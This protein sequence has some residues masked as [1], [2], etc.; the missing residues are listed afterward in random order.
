M[1]A[2]LL[3]SPD[4]PA[5]Q[6]MPATMHPV[7]PGALGS[8]HTPTD[9][10]DFFVQMPAQQ[11]VSF[12]QMSLVWVQNETLP[13]HTPLLQTCEQHSLLP[14]QVLPAVLQAVLSGSQ[15]ELP[16]LPL[17]HWASLVQGCWSDVQ[18]VAPHLPPSHTSVQHSVGAVQE[19]PAALQPPTGFVHVFSV[20]SQLAEQHSAEPLQL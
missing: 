17:Q 18:S 3:A 13:A 15:P 12:A 2:S 1:P 6:T 11:S 9:A 10:P 8:V 19:S 7:V 20:E 16:Q 4:A 5:P 14:P